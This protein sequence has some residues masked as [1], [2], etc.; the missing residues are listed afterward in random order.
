MT[1]IYDSY[2][3]EIISTKRQIDTNVKEIMQTDTEKKEEIT[4]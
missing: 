3:K 4:R 2:A 1:Q